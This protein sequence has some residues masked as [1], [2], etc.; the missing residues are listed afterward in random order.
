MV[1]EAL[2]GEQALDDLDALVH[3]RTAGLGID[4]PGLQFL[5]LVTDAEAEFEP[6]AGDHVQG[7][8]IFRHAHRIVQRQQQHAGADVDAL[9]TGRDGAA[10]GQHRR[11]VAVVEEVVLGEPD[12]VEAGR[13][14]AH[15]LIEAVVVERGEIALPLGRVAEVVP[16]P[17]A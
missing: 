3:A 17:E 11:R 13:F 10:D 12:V 4:A 5:H 2:A 7:G 1:A 15:D 14:R 9:G 8:R 6:P 16:Q